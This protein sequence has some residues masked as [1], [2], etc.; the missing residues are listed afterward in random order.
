MERQNTNYN[1]WKREQD[2]NNS[3][4]NVSRPFQSMQ[5]QLVSAQL[6]DNATADAQNMRPPI[7]NIGKIPNR[8]GYRDY[9]P[10]IADVLVVDDT[11]SAQFGDFSGVEGGFASTSYPSLPQL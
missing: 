7:P 6:V 8:F 5:E 1:P 9:I 10:G 11:F 3:I 4:Y 2:A